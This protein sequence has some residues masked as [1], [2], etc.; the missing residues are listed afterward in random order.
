MYI[1]HLP[2]GHLSANR[3]ARATAAFP[4]VSAA[5]SG[6]TPQNRPRM[7]PQGEIWSA[8]MRRLAATSLILA[9]GFGLASFG[10][11]AREQ[12]PAEKRIVPFYGNLPACEDAG[13]LGTLSSR[14]ASRESGYWNSPLTIVNVEYPRQTAYR[15]NGIDVVP[16]R[17]CT[18]TVTTSDLKRR[19]V[20]YAII[21]GDGFIGF[22]WGL[23]YCVG[24]LD[25]SYAY[26]PYCKM[27]RP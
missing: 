16:R 21:E 8:R 5:G 9:A 26:A 4:V 19:K 25:R 11:M 14:F 12:G 13:V 2:A 17:Y 1:L 24:G 6:L 3:N 20:D 18:A 10:A 27:A 15:T 23:E 7:V 22:S